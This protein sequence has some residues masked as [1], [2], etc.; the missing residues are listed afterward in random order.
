MK[1]ADEDD[2]DHAHG[3]SPVVRCAEHADQASSRDVACNEC[4]VLSIAATHRESEAADAE[5]L[6]SGAIAWAE[7][8]LI[9][10][11]RLPDDLRRRSAAHYAAHGH[12]R[13]PGSN[14]LE[15]YVRHH[16]TNYDALLVTLA[17]RFPAAPREGLTYSTLRHRVD[18]IVH[19]ALD[20]LQTRCVDDADD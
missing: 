14:G 15:A 17:E 2:E 16:W 12:E 10:V 8:V 20:D 7:T 5:E 1:H 18:E 13:V 19:D 6:A 4:M 9:T 11:D 3:P